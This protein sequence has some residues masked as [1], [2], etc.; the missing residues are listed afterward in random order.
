MSLMDMV[1]RFMRLHEETLPSMEI[2]QVRFIHSGLAL[3]HGADGKTVKAALLE[4]VIDSAQGL[5]QV[6]SQPFHHPLPE[7]SDPDYT[8]ACFLCFAQHV[9]WTKTGGIVFLSDFQGGNDL[10]TD[11]QIMTH[12]SL[13]AQFSQ[14]NVGAAFR[15]FPDEHECNQFVDISHFRPQK[16]S[17]RIL[18][19]DTHP[20]APATALLYHDF[21][22]IHLRY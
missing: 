6:C 1:Y 9:Q 19:L 12:P 17:K 2:P 10:L 11:P 8:L 7:S 3:I 15:A 22:F 18:V 21:S 13:N 16:P 4:E 5:P 20:L 14:G